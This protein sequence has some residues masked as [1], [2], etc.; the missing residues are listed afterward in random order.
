MALCLW[1]NSSFHV[2]VTERNLQS[3]D[4]KQCQQAMRNPEFNCP[5]ECIS[6]PINSISL[7]MKRLKSETEIALDQQEKKK[8]KQMNM[9]NSKNRKKLV[10]VLYTVLISITDHYYL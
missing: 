8:E 4:S 7:F 3:G 10:G 5:T 9:S 2:S 1:Q 6:Q